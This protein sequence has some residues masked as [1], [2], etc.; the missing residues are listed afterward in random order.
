MEASY[1]AQVVSAVKALSLPVSNLAGSNIR[2]V[3]V[4]M[5]NPADYFSAYKITVCPSTG[6]LTKAFVETSAKEAKQDE[7]GRRQLPKQAPSPDNTQA[8]PG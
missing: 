4:I 8:I 5:V 7:R 2:I 1:V 6:S 3:P